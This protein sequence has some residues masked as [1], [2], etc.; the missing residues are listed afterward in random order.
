M[1]PSPFSDAGGT[2]HVHVT[3]GGPLAEVF[4]IDHSFSLVSR[5]VGVL[6]ADVEQGVYKV[7]AQ[8]GE[9]SAERVVILNRDQDDRSVA[10]APRRLPRAAAGHRADARI[11]HGPCRRRQQD[12][13]HD[14]RERRADLPV[15]PTLE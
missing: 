6:D 13:A 3:A 14:H 12:G 2:V 9:A 4:L 1:Q 15:R 7:K 5:A 8:L 11:P 10:R